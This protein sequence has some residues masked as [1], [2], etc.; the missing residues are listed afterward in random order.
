MPSYQGQIPEDDLLKIIE[1]IKSIGGE[2][3]R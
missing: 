3:A 2:A 1:Y